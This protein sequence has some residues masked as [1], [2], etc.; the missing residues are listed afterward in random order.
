MPVNQ[1]GYRY[2]DEPVS[3]NNYP[4]I[5]AEMERQRDRLCG[6]R[7]DE[8]KPV[9]VGKGDAVRWEYKHRKTGKYVVQRDAPQRRF[10][11]PRFE[12]SDT[13]EDA[14]TMLRNARHETAI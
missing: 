9:R 5:R 10:S 4:E 7:L 3:V 13:T 11:L 6:Y 8:I 1:Y 12:W 2:A 14:L